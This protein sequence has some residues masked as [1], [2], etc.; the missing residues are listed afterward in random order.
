MLIHLYH[1]T[2]HEF[3]GSTFAEEDPENVGCIICPAFSTTVEP[4]VVGTY[5]KALFDTDTKTWFVV[6]DWR[7]VQFY[8]KE[9]GAEV[10]RLTLTE[11]PD[12][13]LV[14]SEPPPIDHK[15]END[16]WVK[17]KTKSNL[18]EELEIKNSLWLNDAESVRSIREWILR[19]PVTEQGASIREKLSKH[20]QNAA[21]LRERLKAVSTN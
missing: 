1:P 5:E 21:D 14:T 19:Q 17:D 12:W 8:S 3:I 4:P 6:A 13:N 20:E 18:R 15:W 2:T 9:T 11:N 7:G 16:G 10:E